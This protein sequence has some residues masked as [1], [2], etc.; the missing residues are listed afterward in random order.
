MSKER[1]TLFLFIFTV[2][3]IFSTGIIYSGTEGTGTDTIGTD[4]TNLTFWDVLKGVGSFY[5]DVPIFGGLITAIIVGIGVYV[6][7]REIR[8]GI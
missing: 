6:L 2:I 4:T 5:V 3:F 8:G 1:I 7:Y